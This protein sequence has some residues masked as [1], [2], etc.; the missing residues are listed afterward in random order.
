MPDDKSKR[1]SPD[2]KRLNKNED[3]EIAAAAKRYGV[4]KQKV[5]DAIDA[6]GTSM[7]KVEAYL[8]GKK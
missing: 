1:G 7:A 6:V 2:D 3:Y 4:T 5:L 8:K